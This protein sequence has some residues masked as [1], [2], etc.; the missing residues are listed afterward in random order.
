M[1]ISFTCP[2]A[3][4]PHPAPAPTESTGIPLNQSA[5]SAF[6]HLLPFQ[7]WSKT[8]L[9][10]SFFPYSYISKD[11]HFPQLAKTPL[12]ASFTTNSGPT[13]LPSPKSTATI[14]SASPPRSLC[15]LFRSS[16]FLH[17]QGIIH[18][19]YLETATFI[20]LLYRNT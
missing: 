13:P 5:S 2:V 20:C 12:S 4:K 14:T 18:R 1:H 15:H 16:H 9:L 11:H 19:E 10:L 6:F 3:V 7:P 17:F 8:P